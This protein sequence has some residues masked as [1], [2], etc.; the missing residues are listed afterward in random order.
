MSPAS[1]KSAKS[2]EPTM[3]EIL[4]S[5]RRIIADDQASSAPEEEPEEDEVADDGGPNSQA[6]IDDMFGDDA[7]EEPEPEPEPEPEDEE[8]E[9]L[10]LGQVAEP[11]AKVAREPSPLDLEHEDIDFRHNELS[12]KPDFDA[13]PEPEPEPEPEIDAFEEPEPV[14]EEPAPYV[15]PPMPEPPRRRMVDEERLLSEATD[16][17]VGNHFNMLAHAVLSNQ[18]RTLEDLV[19]EMLRPMLKDW[20]DDNLPSIVERLVRAEIERVS[21]GR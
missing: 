19:K 16:S 18:G 6:S 2:E 14:F 1:P 7:E 13:L 20:L 8:E 3:E 15:P 17:A 5:I 12:G 11:V 10:D 9:V 21:R 4:A